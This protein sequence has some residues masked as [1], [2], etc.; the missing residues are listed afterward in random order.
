MDADTTKL[1]D[2]RGQ[3]ERGEYEID[4]RAVADALVARVQRQGGWLA[5]A[6]RPHAHSRSVRPERRSGAR[7]A[8]CR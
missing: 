8:A 4:P 1:A 5:P 6:V 7:R 3:I 2:L